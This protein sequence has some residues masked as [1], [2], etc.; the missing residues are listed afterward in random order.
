MSSDPRLP[1]LTIFYQQYLDDHDS[2]RFA[3]KARRSYAQGTLERLAGHEA[4]LVRRSAVIALG[5][6]GDYRSNT[7]LGKA[8]LDEDRNVRMLAEN[9]IRKVWTR[10]GNTTQRRKLQLILRLNAAEQH[11]EAER[12]ATELIGAAPWLAEAW[13][14]RAVARSAIEQ[15]VEAI[16]DANE[17]L[18]LNPY[19]FEAAAEMGHAYLEL[20]NPLSA[21]QCFRRALRLNPNQE[22]VRAQVHRL[23][24]KIEGK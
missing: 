10:L 12:R 3:R 9:G 8:L 15:F 13:H 23:A 5:L 21:L 14:Q 17:A 24:R 22:G 1:L 11:D 18:E 19:H 6:L 16:R 4:A 7:T 20:K 2:D